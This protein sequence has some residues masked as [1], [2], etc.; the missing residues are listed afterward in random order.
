MFSRTDL[1]AYFD[2]IA[3][4]GPTTPNLATLAGI[5]ALQPDAISFENLDVLLGRPI[6]LDPASLHRKL[7]GEGRGG[8]CFEQ[9][10]LLL[11]VLKSLGFQA[12]GLAGRVR[13]NMPA[14]RVTGRSHMMI[15]VDLPEGPF[16]ADVGF[17]GLTQT[18]PLAMVPDREQ[19]SALDRHRLH[20]VDGETMLQAWIDGAWSD[21]V[22]F[23]ETPQLQIDYEMASCFTSTHPNSLFVGNLLATRTREDARLRL[24]NAELTTRHR[25]GSVEERPLDGLDAVI[26]VLKDEMRL[27]LDG[28]DLARL[29][30]F[31][32]S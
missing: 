11:A 28:L 4:G 14:E 13:F 12:T 30:R 24:F 19:A 9:N 3:Y 32:R 5:H 21:V 17:G 18:I 29:G 6:L 22:R 26:A 1:D 20:P 25:D 27:T 16:L 23:A 8:Y 10:G 15:R 31:I 7:V 2:R